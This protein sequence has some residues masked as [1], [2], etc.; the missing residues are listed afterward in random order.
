MHT[1]T[2]TEIWHQRHPDCKGIG[3]RA[4][5][6][7]LYIMG[8]TPERPTH[9]CQK[10]S[11]TKVDYVTDTNYIDWRECEEFNTNGWC[12]MYKE[13]VKECK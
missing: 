11:H 12:P 10:M 1:I 9:C 4:C 3:E 5:I 6:N 8:I 7:C 2:P 13:A